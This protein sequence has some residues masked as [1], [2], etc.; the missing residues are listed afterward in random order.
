M[1]DTK[2]KSSFSGRGGYKCYCC[3]PAP[4][5]RKAHR[6]RIKRGR[7]KQFTVVVIKEQTNDY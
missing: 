5:N 3:G 7:M 4:K 2:I 1:S 6:R